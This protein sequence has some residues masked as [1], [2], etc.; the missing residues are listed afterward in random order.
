MKILIF[1]TDVTV[2][3]IFS[4]ELA[5]HELIFIE[6]PVNEKALGEHG[7]AAV[8]SV[9]VSSRLTREDMALL[10][11]L[12]AVIAR[13]SGV[14]HID[15][16]YLKEKDI[17]LHSVPHYGA[18][19]VAEYAFALLLA[20][21]RRLPAA[22]AQAQADVFDKSPKLEGGD[23]YGKTIGVIGTGA[24]GANLV[25]RAC[26]FGMRVLMHDL[27][28]NKTLESESCRYVTLDEL[29]AQSDIISLH[30]PGTP[31][32]HHLLSPEA[33]KKMKDGVIIVNTARGELIDTEALLA[34][35]RSGKVAHAALD[36]I[37]GE[38]ELWKGEGSEVARS[39]IDEFVHGTRRVIY[40]PHIAFFTQEAYHEILMT[41]VANT[42][43]AIKHMVH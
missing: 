35:L 42:R 37:E 14:D 5:E 15:A 40:T 30:A 22:F 36:V 39:L 12:R 43:E 10:P 23:V 8:V 11:G 29:Y 9:F 24:I 16:V 32:T 25:Q 41:S 21:T 28:P 18:H 31:E 4:R 20:L 26:A 1:D 19:T 33:F 34:A 7:D 6:G 27:F 2:R 3:E 17:A 13:S 38:R